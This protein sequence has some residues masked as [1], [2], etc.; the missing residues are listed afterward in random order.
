MLLN[1][2]YQLQ[3]QAPST[4]T[5]GIRAQVGWELRTKGKISDLAQGLSTTAMVGLLLEQL[6]A[7]GELPEGVATDQQLSAR[8]VDINPQGDETATPTSGAA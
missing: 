8:L 4:T 5:I 1:I 6:R 3:D 7:D 2:N